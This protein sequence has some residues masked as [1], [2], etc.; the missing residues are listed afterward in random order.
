M[1]FI[2]PTFGFLRELCQVL[3]QVYQLAWA[4]NAGF[5]VRLEV[6]LEVVAFLEA[7]PKVQRDVGQL[8]V[9]S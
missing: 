8:R 6:L 1:A 3:Y 4:F 9:Y 7:V 2:R 5:D